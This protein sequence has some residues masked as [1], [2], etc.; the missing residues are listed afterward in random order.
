M[1]LLRALTWLFPNTTNAHFL[2]GMEEGILIGREEMLRDIIQ[3]GNS[4]RDPANMDLI[5]TI[6]F[7]YMNEILSAYPTFRAHRQIKG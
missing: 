5:V 1:T 6:K 7:G 3:N 4:R 2:S